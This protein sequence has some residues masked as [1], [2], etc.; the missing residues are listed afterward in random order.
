VYV[1]PRFYKTARSR[2]VEEAVVDVAAAV[3]TNRCP[4]ALGRR[5]LEAG[6]DPRREILSLK[7]RRGAKNQNRFWITSKVPA[8]NMSP[9][10][11]SGASAIDIRAGAETM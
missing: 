1:V 2:A 9:R 11:E 3:A 8:L 5:R 6:F 10:P 4:E 7:N